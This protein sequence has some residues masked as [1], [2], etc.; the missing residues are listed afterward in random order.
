MTPGAADA[1][2]A[3]TENPI[4]AMAHDTSDAAGA[5]AASAPAAEPA[6]PGEIAGNG[7][8]GASGEGSLARLPYSSA[9]VARIAGHVRGILDELGLDLADPN[10]AETD[11][12]VAEM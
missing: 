4:N 8:F 6:N 2:T 1:V 3:V 7:D 12:R 9:Q 5:H 11:R 10:L